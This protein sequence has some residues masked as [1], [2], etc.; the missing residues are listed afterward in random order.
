VRDATA[1]LRSALRALPEPLVGELV[2][3][4]EEIVRNFRQGRWEP[5]QLNGGKFSEVVYTITSGYVDGRYPPKATKPPNM[6]QACRDLERAPNSV[7]R[8]IKVHI[9]R[10]LAVLYEFRNNR[11]VGHVG[12][13]V[14]PNK[15]DSIMVV[16]MAKWVMAELVR[17]F[18]STDTEAATALVDALVEREVPLVWDVMGKRRVLV[19]GMSMKNKTLILLHGGTGTVHESDLVHWIECPNAGVY[20]RDVL[21]PAHKDRLIEFDNKTGSVAISPLGIAFVEDRLL[22]DTPSH[23]SRLATAKTRHPRTAKARGRRPA[24]RR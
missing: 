24:P 8:S 12:G 19:P 22:A 14:D 1:Q 10:A 2:A 4:F 20:R 5:S 16:S 23:G 15:M 9:P 11:G 21:R 13:D 7:P 17:V 3:R 6:V 18:H